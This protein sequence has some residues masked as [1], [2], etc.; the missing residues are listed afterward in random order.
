MTEMHACRQRWLLLTSKTLQQSA[1]DKNRRRRV[2]SIRHA[3]HHISV[4]G[5]RGEP[6]LQEL[7]Q[8]QSPESYRLPGF[9]QGSGLRLGQV[10]TRHVAPTEWRA[11]CCQQL[12]D[13]VHNS[14]QI[15]Q[16]L[17]I[18]RI[19]SCCFHPLAFKQAQSCTATQQQ[20]ALS[21][22]CQWAGT[23]ASHKQRHN[24]HLVAI[25]QWH[26]SISSPNC[27]LICAYASQVLPGEA[28]V[29]VVMQILWLHSYRQRCL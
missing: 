12:M 20:S 6:C 29:A 14:L 28:L 3:S 17:S 21:P 13:Q 5:A 16:L 4:W 23:V 2:M 18:C 25:Q 9:P 7:Q 22:A 15:P 26:A 1:K 11:G 8:K 10:Q 19:G 24:A 27:K